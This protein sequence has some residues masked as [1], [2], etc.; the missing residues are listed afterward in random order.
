MKEELTTPP[1]NYPITVAQIRE[2]LNIDH[3]DDD[4]L[5]EIYLAQAIDYCQRKTGIQIG[6]QTWTI[7]GDTW[8]DVVM[9]YYQPVTD[10]LINY[11]AE[12][13]DTMQMLDP[14]LYVV[15]TKSYPATITYT[16]FE[17]L[18]PLDDRPNN[19]ECRVTTGYTSTLS[20]T[21]ESAIY[22]MTGHLY[23]RREATSPIQIY[24]VPLGVEE[25]LN[26]QRV[27]FL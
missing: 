6:T 10:V 25:M 24:T 4:K 17:N 13:G 16:D 18:P 1:S 21:L 22:L 15:D 19:V 27:D 26:T 2:H 8:C 12:G 20:K 14:A 7:Y 3:Y 23:E 5:L 9:L 11:Y